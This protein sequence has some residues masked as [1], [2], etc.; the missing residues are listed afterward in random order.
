MVA[1]V[2]Q[3][4]SRPAAAPNP[5][6][7]S[8][9]DQL[10]SQTEYFRS[11]A[12]QAE[13]AAQNAAASSTKPIP[14][15]QSS[16]APRY[17]GRQYVASPSAPP[18]P[19]MPKSAM[20]KPSSSAAPSEALDYIS[21]YSKPQTT[22]TQPASALN[23][24]ESYSK[25]S[26]QGQ[27]TRTLPESALNYVES[28]RNSNSQVSSPESTL[29]HIEKYSNTNTSGPSPARSLPGTHSDRD[30]GTSS[31]AASGRTAPRSRR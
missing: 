11:G 16:E 12:G 31:S 2:S 24:I 26:S 7:S 27:S 30:T 14:I 8:Y 22:K 1:T 13:Q 23:Y 20:K 5:Q 19:N 25:P 28:Y 18:I 29:N 3:G 21:Y 6:M 15:A 17:Q 9:S 4:P 10:R